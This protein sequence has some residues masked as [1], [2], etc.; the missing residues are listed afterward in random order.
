MQA[1]CK[2]ALSQAQKWNAWAQACVAQTQLTAAWQAVLQVTITRRQVALY[3]SICLGRSK[4]M[5]K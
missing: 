3:H 2:A 5:G 1:A 4:V